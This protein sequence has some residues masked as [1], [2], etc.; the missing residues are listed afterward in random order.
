M[1]KEEEK[2]QLGESLGDEAW[3]G[4]RGEEEVS[5]FPSLPPPLP[6]VPRRLPPQPL[7]AAAAAAAAR[8]WSVCIAE[9]PKFANRT[10]FMADRKTPRMSDLV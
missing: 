8:R 7:A 10:Y 3:K 2:T 6:S 5:S 4:K 1:E 9:I